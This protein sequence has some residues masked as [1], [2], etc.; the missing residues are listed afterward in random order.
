LIND[1][2]ADNG[3]YALSNR[4]NTTLYLDSGTGYSSQYSF[5]ARSTIGTCNT[6]L[7]GGVQPD[8]IDRRNTLT[9]TLDGSYGTLET[10]TDAEFYNGVNIAFIGRQVSGRWEGELISWQDAELLAVGQYRLSGLLRGV[11]GTEDKI[12][13]H[14]SG[15]KFFLL[16]G[17]GAYAPRLDGSV[18][19]IGLP[20]KFKLVSAAWE[21]FATLPEVMI[22]P[23]GSS[24]KPFAPTV[25][26][27]TLD[28]ATGNLT[29]NWARQNRKYATMRPNGDI[30]IV[31]SPEL[32]YLDIYDDGDIVRS[33]STASPTYTYSAA[34]QT[35]DFGGLQ[36]TLSIAFS[37]GSTIVG[38][39]YVRSQSVGINRTY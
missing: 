32:Y 18:N 24:L 1:D 17:D 12:G 29:L 38:R 21:E 23:Q 19:W 2:H 4:A 5:Y 9:V 39:G 37:Q 15:E 27:L 20:L 34:N 6:T 3:L 7:G 30:P 33:L 8:Y 10:L 22:T 13:W 36:T 14:T 31:E 26:I 16:A 28:S 35:S 25:P 11:R